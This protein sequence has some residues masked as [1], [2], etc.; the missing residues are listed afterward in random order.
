[1]EGLKLDELKTGV[2]YWCLLMQKRVLVT[3][4]CLEPEVNKLVSVKYYEQQIG[5][6]STD[7]VVDYQ[8]SIYKQ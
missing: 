7:Y 1:M 5:C 3:F 2:I 4:I 6:Y 8:L